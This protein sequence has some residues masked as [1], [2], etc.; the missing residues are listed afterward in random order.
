MGFPKVALCPAAEPVMLGLT[1][2]PRMHPPPGLTSDCLWQWPLQPAPSSFL[3]PAAMSVTSR[4]S[5]SQPGRHQTLSSSVRSF[6]SEMWSQWPIMSCINFSGVLLV[7]SLV[8][9]NK[10]YNTNVFLCL[11]SDC[12]SS[13]SALI[14]KRFVIFWHI[15]K[16]LDI[17]VN[18]LCCW[19]STNHVCVM[20]AL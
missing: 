15:W 3:Q 7:V 20:E 4:R 19:L 1:V 2:E 6:M 12:V 9:C 10:Y 16:G 17:T 8:F 14:T 18:C 5:T 11:K 13:K